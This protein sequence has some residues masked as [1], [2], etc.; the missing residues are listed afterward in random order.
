MTSKRQ[1]GAP[2]HLQKTA[3]AALVLALAVTAGCSSLTVSTPDTPASGPDPGY[4]TTVANRIKSSFKDHASYDAFEISAYRW[5]HSVMGWSWLTCVR[6]QDHGHRRTY[7]LFLRGNDI[8]ESRYAV[9]AD[10]CDA[11][12]YVPFDLMGGAARPPAPGALDPLY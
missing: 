11:I 12:S 9:Q 10:G 2:R 8:I 3:G 4:D 5:V 1:H 7:A 6:F